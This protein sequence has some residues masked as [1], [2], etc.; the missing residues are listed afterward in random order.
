[1]K[2]RPIR[3][4]VGIIGGGVMGSAL[5]CFLARDHDIAP[6]VFERDPTYARASSALSASSIRQQFSN[7]VNIRLSQESLAFYRRIGE[8]LAVSSDPPPRIGLVERGYLYLVPE[9]GAGL[10]RSHHNLQRRMG[11][12][13]T[14]L[15]PPALRERFPWL[16]TDG[17]ALG[18]LG[19]SGEGWFDGWSVLQA[20]RRKAIACGTRFVKTGVRRL[21]TGP[22]GLR[23]RQPSLAAL[24]RGSAVTGVMLDDG[25]VQPFDHVVVAAGAWSAPLLAPLGIELPVRARKRDVFVFDAPAMLDRCPLV[26]DPS[27]LWFRPEGSTRGQA[28]PSQRFLCGAPPRGEDL[29]DQP[30]E[31]IDH[32]LFDEVLWPALAARVPAF[33]SLRVTG[34]WAGYYEINTFDHNGLVGPWPG[35]EGLSL[36]CGFSGHGMQQAPAAGRQLA[37]WIAAEGDSDLPSLDPGRILRGERLLELNVI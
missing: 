27:G 2:T 24:G 33:E 18:S 36:A 10:L 20:F 22:A 1:M 9:S 28:S 5:A 31:S 32:G 12:D 25:T 8:E 35:L 4:S 13:V 7:A 17:I 14:L 23:S 6:V 34:A 11:A 3:P 19:Q 30:L 15:S 29:D 26:I 21:V 37:A 16:A